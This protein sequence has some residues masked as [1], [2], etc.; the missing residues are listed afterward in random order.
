ML[1]DEQRRWR[2]R[3][4]RH[5]RWGC[6]LGLKFPTVKLLDFGERWEQLEASDYP[7][8]AVIMAHLKTQATRRDSEERARWKLALTRW[9]LRRGWSRDDILDLYRFVD[10]LMALP[11]ELQQR[12]EAT[13]QQ[14]RGEQTMEHLTIW[15]RRGMERGKEEGLKEGVIQ[16]LEVRFGTVPEEVVAALGMVSDLNL[17][18][19]LHRQAVV[20]ES[21]DG[22]ASMLRKRAGQ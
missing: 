18:S 19:E 15:E 9:L 1:A 13:L 3:G 22:L 2:P 12:H 5:E 14:D 7:F 8:A 21:L 11:E 17:L 6:E 16:A 4:Y 20:V 10:W